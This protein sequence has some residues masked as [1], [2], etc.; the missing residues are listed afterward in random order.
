MWKAEASGITPNQWGR[1]ANQSAPDY[2]SRKVFTFEYKRLVQQPV[3]SFFGAFARCFNLMLPSI[4][5][6]LSM[7]K[8]MPQC[9]CVSCGKVMREIKRHVQTEVGTS[10]KLTKR[11]K[12]TDH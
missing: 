5:N 12:E 11:K 10:K 2:T 1:R 4:S 6:L 7:K 8:G 3:R 9:V